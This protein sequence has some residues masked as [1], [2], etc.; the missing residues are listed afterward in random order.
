MKP[1]P[2]ID[3]PP[4]GRRWGMPGEPRT[5]PLEPLDQKVIEVAKPI[6][7]AVRMAVAALPLHAPFPRDMQGACVC[8]SYALCLAL[9]RAG[10][11]AQFVLREHPLD[12]VAHA[13]VEVG[14]VVID[15][16]ATQFGRVRRVHFARTYSN[17][18]FNY[19]PTARGSAALR[20]VRE[21]VSRSMDGNYMPSRDQLRRIAAKAA[22]AALRS[23]GHGS[24]VGSRSGGRQERSKRPVGLGVPRKAP[25]GNGKEARRSL[26]APPRR[27]SK[28]T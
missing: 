6:A 2:L 8:V 25:R 18:P 17:R 3:A 11:Q 4:K 21:K 13:W 27:R 14:E 20:V 22:R 15:A 1:R 16:T 23:D 5:V 12:S 26:S 24:G 28:K 9:R 19:F 7:L 10:L